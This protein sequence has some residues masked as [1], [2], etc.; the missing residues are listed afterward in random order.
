[1][2]AVLRFQ[3]EAQVLDGPRRRVPDFVFGISVH[4]DLSGCLDRLL[5][6]HLGLIEE[7]N[8]AKHG[9]NVRERNGRGILVE[10]AVLFGVNEN[11]EDVQHAFQNLRP[12]F[13]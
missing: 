8:H 4:P 2:L 12:L 11:V 9:R 7:A 1:M 5:I 3:N 10:G 6:L 13:G